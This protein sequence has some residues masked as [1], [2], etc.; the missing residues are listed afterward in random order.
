MLIFL[1]VILTRSAGSLCVEDGAFRE[2][3]LYN[4]R[5]N[6]AQR[7]TEVTIALLIV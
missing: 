6:T 5:V 2:L 1:L 4:Q 3:N 7:S